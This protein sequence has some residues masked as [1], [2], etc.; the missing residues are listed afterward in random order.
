MVFLSLAVNNGPPKTYNELAE[1]VNE[2]NNITKNHQDDSHCVFE[3]TLMPKDQK[4]I[5]F[6]RLWRSLVHISVTKKPVLPTGWEVRIAPK[7][8]KPYYLNHATKTTHWEPPLKYPY[9]PLP[10]GAPDSPASLKFKAKNSASLTLKQFITL[11][12]KIK[13]FHE[14]EAKHNITPAPDR[15]DECVI[16]MERQSSVV[17]ECTHSFCKQCI[18]DWMQ[19]SET[20]PMCRAHTQRDEAEGW[21][22]TPSSNDEIS[23]YFADFLNDAG[24]KQKS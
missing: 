10:E 14:S 7:Q 17:L 8:S 9:P 12:S 4:D 18:D 21:V 19:K 24:L 6:P 15:D 16:C 23:Q 11:Y 3:F 22:L 13:V 2:L 1:Q 5:M 20:C